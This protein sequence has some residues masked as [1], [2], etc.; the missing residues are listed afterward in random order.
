MLLLLVSSH[1]DR[2][3]GY[4]LLNYLKDPTVRDLHFAPIKPQM[5]HPRWLSGKDP[6]ASAGDM[7]LI[8]GLGGSSGEGND[9]PLQHSC[10]GNSLDRGAWQATVHG[11]TKE[12]D[13]TE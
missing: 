8:P 2:L 7:G 9:N 10:L 13:M 4:F 6:H 12:S 5:G 3:G 11:V 1:K